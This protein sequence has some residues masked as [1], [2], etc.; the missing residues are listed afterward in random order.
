ML[1]NPPLGNRIAT[2]I[3][4]CVCNKL[5]NFETPHVI[6]DTAGLQDP[7]AVKC[8]P[9]EFLR[10]MGPLLRVTDVYRCP[11]Q[12]AKLWNYGAPLGRISP[13]LDVTQAGRPE[14]ITSGDVSPPEIPPER[15][16]L[17]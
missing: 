7:G 11:G 13:T 17:M 12:L 1:R 5:A 4:A 2:E 6:W 3:S 16:R 10:S 8:E 15:R 14:Q 9:D